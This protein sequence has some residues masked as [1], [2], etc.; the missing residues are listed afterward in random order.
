MRGNPQAAS[1]RLRAAAPARRWSAWL[2][3]AQENRRRARLEQA[4]VIVRL[5]ADDRRARR[6]GEHV[7]KLRP[8][9]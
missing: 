3:Q 6:S 4:E 7:P 5:L 2:E 9:L 1:L 8:W